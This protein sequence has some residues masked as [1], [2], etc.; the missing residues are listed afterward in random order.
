M[1]LVTIYGESDRDFIKIKRM[2]YENLQISY[3][4][5]IR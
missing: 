3:Q 4:F 1:P 2:K 5:D